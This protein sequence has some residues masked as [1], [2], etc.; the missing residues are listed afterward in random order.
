MIKFSFLSH[1]LVLTYLTIAFRFL[2]VYGTETWKKQESLET[3][4][5]LNSII[6]YFCC[7]QCKYILNSSRKWKVRKLWLAT[8]SPPNGMKI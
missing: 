4:N 5:L 2:F 1:V 3:I 7:F 8:V 6:L